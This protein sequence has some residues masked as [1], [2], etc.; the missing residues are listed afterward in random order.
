MPR[1]EVVTRMVDYLADQVGRILSPEVIA[2]ETG[3]SASQAKSGMYRVGKTGAWPLETLVNGQ[4]WRVL[5][6]GTA[7][8]GAE[9]DE[10]EADPSLVTY[11]SRPITDTVHMLTDGDG[12]LWMAE[13]VGLAEGS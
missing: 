10:P 6:A 8:A 5:A 9:P 11:H 7:V 13:R 1:N 12:Y 3:L 2:K 4:R